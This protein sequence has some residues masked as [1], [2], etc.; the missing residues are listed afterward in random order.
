MPLKGPSLGRVHA[1]RMPASKHS[2]RVKR[3]RAQPVR[4]VPLDSTRQYS[5]VNV[6]E[7]MNVGEGPREGLS[8]V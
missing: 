5:V 6:L 1:G 4:T 8:V 7:V 2:G 3:G